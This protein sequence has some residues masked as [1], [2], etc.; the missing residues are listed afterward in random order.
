MFGPQRGTAEFRSYTARFSLLDVFS[1]DIMRYSTIS[2]ILFGRPKITLIDAEPHGKRIPRHSLRV[3][4]FLQTT[5]R[6]QGSVR[7]PPPLTLTK[8]AMA[9]VQ[10]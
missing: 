9:G 4:S 6:L 5:T 1:G 2:W 10:H 7:F 3:P 8:T